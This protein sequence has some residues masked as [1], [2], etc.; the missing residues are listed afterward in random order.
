M[1][2][3]SNA[4]TRTRSPPSRRSGGGGT[5][6]AAPEPRALYLFPTK[7]LAQDQVDTLREFG[8]P[9]ISVATYD[10]DTPQRERRPI[11]ER[12]RLLLSNPDM[13]HLG[14]LPQHFRWR[15]FL[16]RLRFVVIDERHVH[17]GGG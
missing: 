8:L 14:I 9:A 4:F 7:A 13:V 10:G 3:R 17:R 2:T 1:P 12:A 5:A 16:H 11:R 6:L 15:A